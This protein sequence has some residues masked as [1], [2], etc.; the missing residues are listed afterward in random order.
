[1][2]PQY[3]KQN[4]FKAIEYFLLAMIQTALR[5]VGCLLSLK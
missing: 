3:R 2:S 4:F 5:D 1:M